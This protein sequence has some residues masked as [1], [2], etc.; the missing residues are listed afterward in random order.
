MDATTVQDIEVWLD[1]FLWP[2]PDGKQR[3]KRR[4][5]LTAATDLFVQYGYRK[6]SIE[7]VAGAAGVAKGTV[8]LYYRNK[9][10][11][12]LH[13]IAL[14]K[15]GYVAKLQPLLAAEVAPL[16]R[17]QALI[18]LGLMA[19]MDM[20]LL[21]RLAGGDRELGLALSEVDAS[22]LERINQFRV[23]FLRSL[24]DAA[25][26]RSLSSQALEERAQVLI[27]LIGGIAVSGVLSGRGG[28]LKLY[29]W[30]VA[31]MLVNGIGDQSDPRALQA[32]WA[33]A[34]DRESLVSPAGA[35]PYDVSKQE[36]AL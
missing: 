23:E 29:V 27:D 22:V 36:A 35:D 25:T 14:E 30:S 5:I 11:L 15:R 10:E 17:L 34:A 4:R 13:A 9:A 6:T 33:P 26:G 1:D 24:L 3:A 19:M 21:S 2:E 31:G 8:Y 12:L 18:A 28:N 16:R 32:I 7:E 20:P